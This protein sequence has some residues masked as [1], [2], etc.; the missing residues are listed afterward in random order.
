MVSFE[1]HIYGE[2]MFTFQWIINHSCTPC[3]SVHNI[4]IERLWVDVTLGFGGKW[5]NFFQDLEAYNALDTGNN[6]HIWLLHHLFLDAINNDIQDWI[7]AW[8]NHV[9]AIQ[10][11]RSRSPRDMFFFGM[12]QYGPR[13]V[14]LVEETMT[15]DEIAQYGIDWEDLDDHHILAHHDA[16]NTEDADDDPV[17]IPV[18]HRVPDHL[19]NVE[20]VEPTCPFTEDQV[21]FIDARIQDQGLWQLC[22]TES[23][24]RRWRIAFEGC[25]CMYIL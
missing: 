12:I 4:R 11:V 24:L 7:G 16:A 3:R 20:V 13:G 19:A 25:Q 9:L 18:E 17:D 1:G 10:G 21:L 5:K 2:G 14:E 23:Y 6:I 8:N 15:K 22:T